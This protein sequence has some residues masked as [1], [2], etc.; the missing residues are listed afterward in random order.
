MV[1]CQP[2]QPRPECWGAAQPSGGKAPTLAE[3]SAMAAPPNPL[4]DPLRR[5]A[6]NV[7]FIP[8]HKGNP[9]VGVVHSL[10]RIVRM[11]ACL[12]CEACRVVGR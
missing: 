2:R 8:E 12:R 1:R 6:V 5:A 3:R 4:P 7:R 11:H 10:A 9:N